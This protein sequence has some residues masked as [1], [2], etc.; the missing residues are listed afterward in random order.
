VLAYLGIVAILLAAC[1]PQ[2]AP[3][4]SSTPS[5]E[6]TVGATQSAGPKS[7][8]I[9]IQREPAAFEPELIGA[10][11]GAAGGQLQ[12]RPIAEDYLVAP[13]AQGG[14]EARL[15]LQKPSVTD[16]TWVVN[17]DGTMDVTW[18]LRP[19]ILWHDGAPFTS[20]DLAF[21]FEVRQDPQ[22]A[23]ISSGGGRPELMQSATATDP[24]TLVVHW[25]Q[26][27][28]LANEGDGLEPL[29]R[30]LLEDIY[31]QDKEA[32]TQS[33][34]LT[35]DYVGEG[36]YKLVHWEQGSH[37]EFARNESYYLGR[38]SFDRLFLRFVPD[39]N[40]L[41]ANILSE[42]VDVVLPP[43]VDLD[44]ALEVQRRWEG[45]GNQV[46]IDVGAEMK[47][48]ELQFRPEYAK[49]AVGWTSRTARQA[50]YQAIDKQTFVE[51]M[52][53]GAAPIADSWYA[54]NDPVRKDVEAYIPPF[55][56]DV[57]RAQ[58]LLAQDGWVRGAD[59]I[60]VHQPRAERFEVEITFQ[61][62]TG[63][64][65]E[66]SIIADGWKAI[67]VSCSRRVLGPI[68]RCRRGSTSMTGGCTPP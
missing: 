2:A 14:T 55:P 66:A 6:R 13:L 35:T 21:A 4:Q 22:L 44:T 41:V 29:P 60:L 53:H 54:P 43:T 36:A 25:K 58:Q 52:T 39:V 37:M 1:T 46:R 33:R 65:K 56:Y 31:R 9:G 26:I 17:A 59:G 50:L 12:V 47:Q 30:H 19:N 38:P 51:V 64:E 68:S 40:T 20:A 45:T 63:P 67:G 27:Y 7:L 15:A 61:Q 8:T 57:N 24:Q 34:Y 10:T 62:G 18:K 48:L 28:V 5:G 32:M 3:G 49:P 23:R 42:T 11:G 16:G